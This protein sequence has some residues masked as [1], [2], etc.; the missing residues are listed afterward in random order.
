LPG[1][2]VIAT[3]APF[4]LSGGSSGSGPGSKSKLTASAPGIE[5]TN[6]GAGYSRPVGQTLSRRLESVGAVIQAD[7]EGFCN[8]QG[9]CKGEA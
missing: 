3:A 2:A 5:L 6:P 1:A 8:G 9:F 4:G 7:G